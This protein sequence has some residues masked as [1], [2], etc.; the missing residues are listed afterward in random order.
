M[1]QTADVGSRRGSAAAPSPATS[2][3]R[4]SAG[5]DTRRAPLWGS[6]LLFPSR[7][8]RPQVV[9]SSRRPGRQRP[10]A[11]LRS[12]L[13][14][15]V[16]LLG[17]RVAVPVSDKPGQCAPW[18]KPSATNADVHAPVRRTWCWRA[19]A[20]PCRR[21]VCASTEVLVE[22]AQARPRNLAPGRWRGRVSA[23]H[24]AAR[25]TDVRKKKKC[26]KRGVYIY[27]NK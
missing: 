3:R 8:V 9:P 21:T 11:A 19:P 22:L 2:T 18:P 16:D 15:T 26:D 27:Y 20:A 13:V 7:P 24:P 10:N 14:V 25:H 6:S 12:R 5:L 23:P 1:G 4:R 17:G